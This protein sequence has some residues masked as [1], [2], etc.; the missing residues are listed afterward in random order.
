[1]KNTRSVNNNKGKSVGALTVSERLKAG[2]KVFSVELFP[3]EIWWKAH[4]ESLF[5]NAKRLKAFPPDFVFVADLDGS[6]FEKAAT[7]FNKIKAAAGGELAAHLAGAKYTRAEIV[8]ICARL[9]AMGVKNIFAVRGDMNRPKSGAPG[10]DY[11]HAFQLITEIQKIGGF[12]IGAACYPEKHSE[13]PSLEKDIDRL[14]QKVDAGAEYLVTQSFF[15]N[16]CYFRFLEK[17]SAAGINVPI[18]PGLM[19]IETYLRCTGGGQNID[20]RFRV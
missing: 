18:L 4:V 1:M 5:Y 14:K 3:P 19:S 13:A 12:S 7:F 2:G 10:R 6:V 11:R 15:D 9:K 17:T 20:R 8:R 16:S